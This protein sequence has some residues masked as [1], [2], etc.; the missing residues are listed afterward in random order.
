MDLRPFLCVAACGAVL[1]IVGLAASGAGARASADGSVSLHPK[2]PP[3]YAEHQRWV[4][5]RLDQIHTVKA[6]MTRAELNAVFLPEGGFYTSSAQTY[7]YRGC[8][9]FRVSVLQGACHVPGT[10]L[11]PGDPREPQRQN[12]QHLGAGRECRLPAK[13]IP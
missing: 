7:L 1:S 13:L 4:A 6:G 9:Y 2:Y 8:P 5:R 11:G 10:R 3:W 12:P